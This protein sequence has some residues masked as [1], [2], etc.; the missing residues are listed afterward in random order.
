MRFPLKATSDDV[1]YSPRT[2]ITLSRYGDNWKAA[3][4][5]DKVGTMIGFY[6]FAHDTVTKELR[7]VYQST[8]SPDTEARTEPEFVID[9]LPGNA[10]Y[11]IMPCTCGE[12]KLRCIR[13][14]FWGISRSTMDK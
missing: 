12:G 2:R 9:R 6:L 14:A 11:T 3:C 4:R 13:A 1:I 8:F 5:K 7:E 10:A